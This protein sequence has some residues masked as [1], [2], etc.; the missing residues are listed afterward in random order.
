MNDLAELG[1]NNLDFCAKAG[2]SA[3]DFDK[4]ATLSDEMADLLVRANGERFDANDT[5]RMHDRMYTL[6]KR[7]INEIR[8]CSRFVFWRDEDRLKGYDNRYNTKPGDAP[9]Y[10]L[11]P[12]W[13]SWIT[14]TRRSF[15][16]I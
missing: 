14:A 5:K 9:F 3:E 16:L 2:Y 15:V 7:P 11:A 10:W 4:A 13:G 12:R 1:R 8:E 6:L